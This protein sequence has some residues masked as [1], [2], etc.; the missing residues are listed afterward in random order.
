MTINMDKVATKLMFKGA[1]ARSMSIYQ[2]VDDISKFI[3]AFEKT[4]LDESNAH[5]PS[6]SGGTPCLGRADGA[7]R[8]KPSG[9]YRIVIGTDS[10][11][12]GVNGKSYVDF[13]SAIIV[14]RIGKGAVYYWRRERVEGRFVIRDKIYRETLISLELAQELV[15]LL[16]KNISSSKYDFEIHIDVG[17][18]GPTREMI[19]EVVGM[20]AG[21]G[22]RARTKPESWGAS[23]VADKHA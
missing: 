9:L 12:K 4:D 20:V 16:R 13:V 11:S 18:V 21:N 19:K 15:P 10:Q 3:E 1:A 6:A 7:I 14:H 23:S 17:S 8:R 2:V 5:K 22:F